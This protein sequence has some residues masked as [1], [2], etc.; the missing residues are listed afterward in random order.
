MK[1]EPCPNECEHTEREH[2]AWDRGWRDGAQGKPYV[3]PYR[4]PAL[5]DAYEWGWDF[6]IWEAEDTR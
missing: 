5:H 3:N 1:P 4:Q 6:G 2:R